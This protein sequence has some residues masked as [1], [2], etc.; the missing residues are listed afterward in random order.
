MLAGARA[1][2][3]QTERA[4]ITAGILASEPAAADEE[5][6][7]TQ[8]GC[9]AGWRRVAASSGGSAASDEHADAAAV[10]PQT[11]GRRLVARLWQQLVAPRPVEASHPLFILYTS[12]STGK[13]K[14]IM[15]TTG[16][17]L[18][19]TYLTSRYT[20]NLR[21]GNNHVFWCTA[22]VGWI[23]GHSYII[24]GILQNSKNMHRC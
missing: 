16:G 2:L 5:H 8:E 19:H 12:G 13:P 10:R 4:R 21:P 18:V 6:T 23:T 1:A 15:H 14:G 24:Y 17:Y 22:D 3:E 20:F 7:H 11:D 9:E